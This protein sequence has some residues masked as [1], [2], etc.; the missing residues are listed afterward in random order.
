VP[1]EAAARLGGGTALGSARCHPGEGLSHPRSWPSGCGGGAW[2]AGEAAPPAGH[3]RVVALEQAK[4]SGVHAG[5]ID[6]GAAKEAVPSFAS[7]D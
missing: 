5:S 2:P 3:R 7:P 4:A 1:V 6:G